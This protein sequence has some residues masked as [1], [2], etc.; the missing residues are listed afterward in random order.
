MEKDDDRPPRLKGVATAVVDPHSAVAAA[1]A[2]KFLRVT[3]GMASPVHWRVKR[4]AG[5]KR[6]NFGGASKLIVKSIKPVLTVRN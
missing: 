2:S 3:F 1:E 5:S 6:R 4:V